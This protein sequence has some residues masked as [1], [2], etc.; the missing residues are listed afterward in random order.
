M[1]AVEFGLLGPLLVRDGG[2][3][4]RLA[5]RQRVLLAAL[6]LRDGQVVAADELAELVWDGR[7]PIG[8]RGALHTAVQRLR[9]ALGV[10]GGGLIGT[11]AP[12]YVLE[13]GDSE[14]D[15]RR[16]ALLAEG[17]RVA[18]ENGK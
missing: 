3:P 5:P 6:L 9:S 4:V 2:G 14:L 7:P 11:C 8:E 16:S 15:T 18:A 10:A 13:L 17:G 1:L 12:G